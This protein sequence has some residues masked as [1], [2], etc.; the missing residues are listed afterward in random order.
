[1]A[2]RNYRGTNCQ[3]NNCPLKRSCSRLGPYEYYGD[4]ASRDAVDFLI[5]ADSPQ[6][7][8]V[9][10]MSPFS[11]TEY[12]MIKDI[13]D[14]EIPYGSYVLT[15][16][17]KGW[18]VDP[19]TP[20]PTDIFGMPKSQLDRHRSISLAQHPQAADT[21]S[22]CRLFLD[23]EIKRYRPKMI[24][25]F[26][27]AVANA[28][29]PGNTKGV[30]ALMEET[31]VFYHN[32]PVRFLQSPAVLT[33]SPASKPSWEKNLR[34]TV[35]GIGFNRDKNPGRSEIITSF[36][37]AMDYLDTLANT[38]TEVA[39]DTETLNLNKRYG[40]KMAMVQFSDNKFGAV[41]LPYLHPESPFGPEEIK[42]L[43]VKLFDLFNK[44]NQVT[45]WIGHN[46]KFENHIF[47]NSFG[48]IIRSAPVFD[49]HVAS[50]LLDENRKERFTE[51]KYSPY[52]LKQLVIDY[53]NFDGYDQGILKEREDGSLFDLP[54]QQLAAYGNMDAWINRKLYF[55]IIQEAKLQN[56]LPQ[57]RG[58]MFGL[59]GLMIKLF[60][61]IEQNGSP[62]SISH[63]RMLN[64]NR[65]PLL[66]KIQEINQEIKQDPYVQQA[67][68]LLLNVHNPLNKK[69]TPIMRP[70]WVYD[71]SKL[72]HPQMLFFSVLGLEHIKTGKSGMHS[73]DDEWQQANKKIPLV[74]KY[75]EWIELRKMHDSFAS[76]LYEHVDPA[77]SNVDSNTDCR[78]RPS[79]LL[80]SVITG[81]I[82]CTNPNLQAIPRSDSGPKATVKNIFQA[83]PGHMMLQVDYKANEMRWVG[84]LAKCQKMAENFI[85]GKAAVDKFRAN[86]TPE[87]GL[88]AK[89]MGDIHRMNAAMAFGKNIFDVTDDERQK[90]KGISFGVLYDSAIFSISELYNIPLREAEAMFSRFYSEHFKILE[91]KTYMKN[92]AKAYSYVETPHGR[93]RRFPIFDL[94]RKPGEPVNE[95]NMPFQFRSVVADAL[96]QS[97][98]APVQGIASDAAIIGAA[99]F[100]EYIYKEKKSWFVQNAVHDS[101]VFQVPFDEVVE[102]TAA[103]EYW[104]TTGV[105]EYM[106]EY[107]GIEFNLPLEIEFEM[108]LKWGDMLKYD[109]NPLKLE[110]FIAMGR[111]GNMGKAAKAA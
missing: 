84:I 44:P 6:G 23:E 4:G 54:L 104:F 66:S 81:R 76:A 107:F 70:P 49:C 94:I 38:A 72:G 19:S 83:I 63:L 21:I 85:R 62:A 56:Y 53:C 65:S 1:V 45:L 10:N 98:N 24:I 50:F 99:L 30:N 35:R 71:F 75:S 90:A 64:S 102:A 89:V 77:G 12:N 51:F 43:N 68:T 15:Y 47:K 34:N 33:R 57:L 97:S 20:L 18:S 40:N 48:T 59:Y 2:D 41:C 74:A 96:R 87:N 3:D 39:V 95:N 5:I 93:R 32:V 17:V 60:S 73:V 11:S 80:A 92:H 101:A 58:L 100:N 36:N 55:D 8:E 14:R 78:I 91:W 16:L 106:T 28:L 61:D 67:N 25:A 110:E 31:G 27:N 46:L 108:G 22:R 29:I 52:S 103:A 109:W 69:I 79:Y 88:N 105:Q 37:E 26:G 7:N 86:P 82:A 13:V 9:A 42:K 111:S